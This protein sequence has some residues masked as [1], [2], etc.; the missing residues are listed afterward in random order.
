MKSI[1]TVD[2]EIILIQSA[3]FSFYAASLNCNLNSEN[4]ISEYKKFC[5]MP[6]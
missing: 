2:L 3:L 4:L 6:M 1:N 5:A